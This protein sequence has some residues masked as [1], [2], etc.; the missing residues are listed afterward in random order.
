[1]LKPFIAA[2]LLLAALSSMA[3][4]DDGRAP[5]RSGGRE[6]AR[7]QALNQQ[8]SGWWQQR[9]SQQPNIS[10]QPSPVQQSLAAGRQSLGF[11]Y[12]QWRLGGRQLGAPAPSFYTYR[13]R[14]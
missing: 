8:W 11:A 7:R 14:R 6:W 10:P 4:A 5:A 1:M 9:Q 13:P 3:A 12:Q 2:T